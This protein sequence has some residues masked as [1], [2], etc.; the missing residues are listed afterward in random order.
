MLCKFSFFCSTTTLFSA[1]TEAPATNQTNVTIRFSVDTT[2]PATVKLFSSAYVPCIIAYRRIMSV[3]KY[4]AVETNLYI[5]LSMCITIKTPRSLL[6]SLRR[7]NQYYPLYQC[8]SCFSLNSCNTK[9][10]SDNLSLTLLLI[11]LN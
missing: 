9:Q 2:L 8:F 11:I 7:L 10:I 4:D 6:V 3:R 5:L 1:F